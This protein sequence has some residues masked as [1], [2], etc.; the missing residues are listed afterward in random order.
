MGSGRAEDPLLAWCQEPRQPR[1][2][3]PRGLSPLADLA[4]L[5]FSQAG[6]ARAEVPTGSLWDGQAQPHAGR[7]PGPRPIGP[8]LPSLSPQ[9]SFHLFLG[10]Q[11]DPDVS[12]NRGRATAHP[13]HSATGSRPGPWSCQDPEG[14]RA[15]LRQAP[16]ALAHRAGS[17]APCSGIA[18]C[19]P[20]PSSHPLSPP[21]ARC[22][23]E[24]PLSGLAL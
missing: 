3:A 12:P 2:T 16:G 20:A 9:E 18:S 24:P 8:F 19:C 15:T 6:W 4:F 17:V 7:T 22:P 13:A 21:W 5:C 10:Q 23:L 14:P 1:P 11:S